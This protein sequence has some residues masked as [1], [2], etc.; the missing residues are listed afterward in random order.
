MFKV[1]FLQ[2]R[3]M[4]F[5]YRFYIA[6]IIGVIIQCI[7]N[8]PLYEFSVT[9]K[10]P[11]NFLEG[12]IYFSADKYSIS[13]AFLGI[14]LAV[15]EIPFLSNI[16]SYVMTRITVKKWSYG[17][18]LYIFLSCIFYYFMILIGSAIFLSSNSF[19]SNSWSKLF[20][21]ISSEGNIL[22]YNLYFPYKYVLR[23]SPLIA[24]F[25]SFILNVLY[26]FTMCLLLFMLCL[27]FRR[28]SAYIT[29]MML[30][31]ISYM[32]LILFKSPIY[33]KASLLGQSMI[34]YHSIDGHRA[35]M[36]WTINESLFLFLIVDVLLIIGIN[37]SVKKY[38][39]KT[40]IGMA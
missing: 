35:D 38:G 7:N 17:K 32:I 19:I 11:L 6:I 30:H 5:S 28:K 33:Y 2:I 13:A 12:F 1:C 8:T 20:Y 36:L 34:V 40:A 27:L 23:I 18:I 24:A 9:M 26:A 16:E 14:I 21:K 25:C 4:F 31:I 39:P 15:S 3:S 37:K 22:S 10:E 29:T